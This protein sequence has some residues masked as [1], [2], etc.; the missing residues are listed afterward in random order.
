MPLETLNFEENEKI[1]V[2]VCMQYFIFS[3]TFR[4]SDIKSI[5]SIF[6]DETKS[7]LWVGGSVILIIHSTQGMSSAIN[8]AIECFI[9]AYRQGGLIWCRW[10]C[11]KLWNSVEIL[12]K[13][14][15]HA[16]LIYELLNSAVKDSLQK[17]AQIAV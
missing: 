13:D 4:P 9:K 17:K 14:F 15:S 2:L 5:K 11:H 16:V 12:M 1:T 3:K 7:F 8:I 10:I 6:I